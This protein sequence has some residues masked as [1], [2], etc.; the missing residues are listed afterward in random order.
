MAGW[1]ASLFMAAASYGEDAGGT[2][3]V[4]RFACADYSQGKVFLVETNGSVAWEHPAPS[5]ND[6]WVLPGGNWLFT[7]GHGV[8]EVTPDKKVVFEYKSPSE[9]YACQRLPDGRTFIGEC[10][11]GRLLDVNPGGEVLKEL[12]LLPAGQDGGHLFMRNARRLPGGNFLV[13]H[14][15]QE[16]VREYDPKGA[17]VWEAKAP[18]GPHSAVRL[19]DGNTLVSVGDMKKDARV[20]EFDREGRKVWEVSNADLAG[21]P[22]RFIAGFH[23]LRNGNT[24][25]CNWL[26]HGQF[27]QAP[28]LLE[29]TRD[30]RVVWTYANH[31]DMKTI[32]T[33]VILDDGGDPLKGEVLH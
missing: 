11:T 4:H 14:Y 10:S 32:S 30:K 24:V 16:L 26:G 8:M 12:P 28:H 20:H 6:L 15:G 23:R 25:I 29:I 22:L 21:A 33:V 17:V 18:G 2:P 27:G 3:I 19:P 13:T 9:I 31:K 5:C 7:T 1:A